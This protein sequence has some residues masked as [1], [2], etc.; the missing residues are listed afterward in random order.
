MRRP[1]TKCSVPRPIGPRLLNSSWTAR[2]STEGSPHPSL[3]VPS[4]TRH[5]PTHSAETSIAFLA[6]DI[7]LRHALTEA[8]VG[9]LR[10]CGDLR[11]VRPR[12]SVPGV[13]SPPPA[14]SEQSGR[15]RRSIGANG[16][17]RTDRVLFRGRGGL[18]FFDGSTACQRKWRLS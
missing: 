17:R 6:P 13:V 10:T 15:A 11:S 4:Y 3:P 16:R 1:P 14:H 18:H 8:I 9:R 12:I 7:A 2:A 5:H